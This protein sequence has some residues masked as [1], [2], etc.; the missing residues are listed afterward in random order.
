[1]EGLDGFASEKDDSPSLKRLRES[2]DV[3]EQFDECP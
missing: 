1:V 2:V 3:P